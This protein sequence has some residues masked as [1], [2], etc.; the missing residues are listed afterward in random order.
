MQTDCFTASGE[1]S[2]IADKT[3]LLEEINTL[4]TRVANGI[5]GRNLW[6]WCGSRG[7]GRVRARALYKNK[8]RTL[9]DLSECHCQKSLPRW[10]R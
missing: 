7:I 9:D 4:R 2:K 6:G 5:N 8:I 1:I 10:T 3:E